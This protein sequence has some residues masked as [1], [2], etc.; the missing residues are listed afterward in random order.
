MYVENPPEI[1]LRD[2]AAASVAGLPPPAEYLHWDKLRHLTPPD[3]LSH[4][5]WWARIKISRKLQQRSLPLTSADGLPFSYVLT[6]E[7]FRLLHFADQ[8]TSG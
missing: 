7:V 6:D 4:R 3:G 8:N 1:S 2:F 5:Q